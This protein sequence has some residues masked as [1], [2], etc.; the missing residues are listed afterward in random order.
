MRCCWW[1]GR[2]DAGSDHHRLLRQ[3]LRLASRSGDA[4]QPYGRLLEP[5]CAGHV[6]LLRA[7]GC[8]LVL[9]VTRV[10]ANLRERDA[11]LAELRRQSVEEVH[12]VRMGPARLRSGALR[13]VRRHHALGHHQGL[14][15]AC[16][17]LLPTR[18]L[19][20]HREM[21]GQLARLQGDRYRHPSV[22]R[23]GAGRGHG[24][25][26]RAPFSRRG[27]GGG[28]AH[29]PARR[30]ASPMDNGFEPDEAIIWISRSGR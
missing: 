5:A 24:A 2:L 10:T 20:G 30:P 26:H 16:R 22:V 4:A 13:W 9:F 8:L 15:R 18:N 21:Q 6:D 3:P 28:L 25:H 17:L 7:G 27:R 23:R 29:G 11:H 19:P 1:P 12:I 14:E